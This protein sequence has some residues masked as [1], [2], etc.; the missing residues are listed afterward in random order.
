MGFLTPAALALG[1]LAVPI[2][3]L[4]MLRMRRREQ[5]VSSTLLWQKLLRDRQANAP[6]QRLHRNWLM[7][8]QLLALAALVL[9]LAR[10]YVRVPGLGSGSTVVLLDASASMLAT[11]GP[12]GATRFEAARAE[13]ERVISGLSGDDRMTLISVGRRPA[14]LAATTNDRALLRAALASAVPDLSPADWQGAF[15]LANAS[16][17]GAPDPSILL[18]SDGQLPPGL[19]ALG[20]EVDYR[21]VGARGDNLALAALATRET[22]DGPALLATVSNAGPA[23]ASALLSL[24][25]DGRLYDARR[26]VVPP[27]GT[28]DEVWTLP[29]AA[30]LIEARVEPQ[31]GA[32]YL[33]ADDRAWAVRQPESTRRVLLVGPG[34]LFLEGIFRILPGYELFRAGQDASTADLLDAGDTP[35]DLYVFDSVPLP[36]ALPDAPALIVNPQPA[37]GA[38][39]EIQVTQPFS[40]TTAIRLTGSPLLQ[41]VDWRAVSIQ[42]GTG[43]EAPWLEPLVEAE[44]GP[45]VLAGERNGQ[46]TVVFAFDLRQTDLPLQ[47]AF[48][49]IMA[50]I[51]SWLSP[52]RVIAATDGL[53]PGDT[54]LLTPDAGSEAVDVQRPDGTVWTQA[55]SSEGGL[56]F[57]DTAQTGVYTV[58]L[59]EGDG[60]VRPAGSFAV[61]FFDPGESRVAPAPEVEIGETDVAAGSSERDGR[62]ELWPLFLAVAI[63]LLLLEWWI[64]YSRGRRPQVKL[65]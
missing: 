60:A 38:A 27:G 39:A 30:G 37:A 57:A 46:R 14:V 31:G 24:F 6:W 36:P 51:T 63:G 18:I 55:V 28:A 40:A 9:A 25:V 2:I 42:Q 47:I 23:A 43:V 12:D 20:A 53:E 8:L 33:P 48:P 17:Q 61:N 3:L 16:L 7:I 26:L 58:S 44:G 54:V 65:R 10:P 1:L 52:G 49:V 29:A 32:D 11:D 15:A 5:I 4:Y 45:L 50:N 22:D 59:R 35:F 34:N 13:V 41:N 21:P 64:A 62:R 19:P 56:V